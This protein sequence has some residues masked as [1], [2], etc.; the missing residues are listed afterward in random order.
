MNVK[1][2]PLAEIHPYANNPRKN[3]EA[4]AGVAASIKRFGFLIPM[5]IDRNGE[6]ICGHTRYK[7]A[8]Q[9]GL[10]EVPCVIADELT[11]DEIRAFRLADNKVSEKATWDMD[12]LPVELAGIM[13]PME[14]F[15]FESISPDDFEENF[16]LDEGEKKPFQQISI[17]VHDKQA[18]LILRAIKYVYDHNAVTE[19]FT[20]ENHNGNGLYEVVREW[21]VQKKLL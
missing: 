15:G 2:I 4:V 16:V 14:D 7:A 8:K 19:T 3:D 12:L 21:A 11:E 6:I 13:L 17:T 20:N 18:A 5:V 9:L 1:T 10:K